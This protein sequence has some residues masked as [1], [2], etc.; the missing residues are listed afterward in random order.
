KAR[1]PGRGRALTRQDR[2]A[3]WR[4]AERFEKRLEDNGVWTWRQLAGRAA[5]L[6]LDREVQIQRTFGQRE[7]SGESSSGSTPR[8]RYRHIVVDEAQDLSAAHWKMLRAM[9]PA[10]ADD[11]FLVGDTHQ[12]IYDNYVTLGSLGVNIRGRSAK[13]T[14]SYRTTR[15]I[16]ATALE[17][18]SGETYDDLD[19]GEENLAGYRSLLHGGRPALH[20]V[21]TWAEEQQLISR[22]IQ[23]WGTAL[24]GSM[25]DGSIAVCLPTRQLAGEVIQ[26]LSED[27]VTAVEIGPDGPKQHDGVHVGTMHRFKG[28]EYRKMII[29][30]VGA[31]LVPRRGIE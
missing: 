22:Q 20:G 4:L 13:L 2:D 18:L 29:G 12:R 21:G 11:M 5:R 7:V 26:R 28:L 6:E 15:Q 25:T 3:V 8:Y 30:G 14:L 31:G 19:G 16:L 1:R 9:V 10:M 24:D 23:A 17:L 27:G